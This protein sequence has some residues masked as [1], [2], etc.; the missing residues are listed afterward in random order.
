MHL[1]RADPLASRLAGVGRRSCLASFKIGRSCAALLEKVMSSRT[2]V[3]AERRRLFLL[4]GQTVANSD[5]KQL[6]VER[7]E[8]FDLT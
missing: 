3:Q 7:T 1:S 6:H 5:W 2:L 8:T 4:G